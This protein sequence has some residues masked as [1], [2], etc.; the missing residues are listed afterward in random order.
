MALS[1]KG[2]SALTQMENMRD[3]GYHLLVVVCDVHERGR[4]GGA[5][6]LDETKHTRPV[7]RVETLARLIKHEDRWTPR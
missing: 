7:E 4:R 6:T 1:A 2:G 5:D 3:A